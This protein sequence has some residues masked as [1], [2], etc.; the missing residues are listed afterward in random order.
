MIIEAKLAEL[1][2]DLPEAPAPV[3][4]YQPWIRAGNLIFTSGQL[5]FRNGEISYAGKLG[6]ELSNEDGYQAARQ[7][8]LNAIAHIKSATGDLDKV[9]TIIRIEGYVHCAEGFRDHPQVLNGASDLIA[10]IFGDRGI[11][12]RLAL[13][14]NEMPLNAAVQLAMIVEVAD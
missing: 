11:H 4:A 5:P 1:G 14:I 9:K 8:A 7:A 12:T 2:I 3:A 10:E 6:A 13:G